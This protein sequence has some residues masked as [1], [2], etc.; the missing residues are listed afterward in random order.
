MIAS[1]IYTSSRQGLFP[2]N[3][4]FSVVGCTRNLDNAIRKQLEDMSGY[5]PLFPHYSPDAWNNPVNYSHR[6]VK[7]GGRTLHVLSRIC[8]NGVDYTQRSNKLA[9][10]LAMTLDE[11][12]RLP[13]GPASVFF[14]Q[15]L[16]KDASW[17]IRTGYLDDISSLSDLNCKLAPCLTWKKLTGDAG[18]AGAIMEDYLLNQDKTFYFAFDPSASQYNL[19]LVNEAMQL[20]SVEQRWK[21]S[22]STFFTENIAGNQCNWRFCPINSDM[23]EQA[24]RN[25]AHNVVFD[26]TQNHPEATGGEMVDLARNGER[27]MKISSLSSQQTTPAV[28][29]PHQGPMI[30][31]APMNIPLNPPNYPN[32]YNIPGNHNDN[33]Y[34]LAFMTCVVLCMVIAG[35]FIGFKTNDNRKIEELGKSLAETQKVAIGVL[36]FQHQVLLEKTEKKEQWQIPVFDSHEAI[37]KET[38]LLIYQRAKSSAK[39]DKT[40][41]KKALELDKEV[42]AIISEFKEHQEMIEASIRKLEERKVLN[43]QV[44]DYNATAEK[45]EGL[46]NLGNIIKINTKE[47][48]D[49]EKIFQEK[50]KQCIELVKKWGDI[51]GRLCNSFPALRYPRPA[52]SNVKNAIPSK[53]IPVLPSIDTAW[54]EEERLIN[55]LKEGKVFM[56]VFEDILPDV[57]EVKVYANKKLVVKDKGTYKIDASH[58][59]FSIEISVLENEIEIKPNKC[60]LK[61]IERLEL[62]IGLYYK[63]HSS[64]FIDFFI[65]DNAKLDIEGDLKY[66]FDLQSA[67]SL[68]VLTCNPSIHKRIEPLFFANFQFDNDGVKQKMEKSK[69][70]WQFAFNDPEVKKLLNCLASLEEFKK[71]LRSKYK[72]KGIV[73]KSIEELG[74]Y[75]K[76]LSSKEKKDALFS[77]LAEEIANKVSLGDLED[78]PRFDSLPADEVKKMTLVQ[79]REFARSEIEKVLD[80]KIEG[81]RIIFTPKNK[82]GGL[83]ETIIP[84]NS[85]SKEGF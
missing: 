24:R 7:V 71:K 59:D 33:G 13:S 14:N 54:R 49:E 21:V 78:L 29:P 10:H 52:P 85:I 18:W 82:E 22:F 30:P 48:N 64:V 66:R 9:S 32:N 55:A 2:G 67:K 20:L 31:P 76:I 46:V 56:A 70:G 51:Q 84:F 68:V 72:N 25:S 37:R 19:E 4:G 40:L 36:E 41:E 60:A 15:G 65:S 81:S 8:F 23:L 63:A 77:E 44:E 27:K 53:E 39:D 62:S 28:V 35:L 5:T 34:K 43:K 17:E 57:S 38:L 58:K 74:A 80:K 75:K 11:C 42:E 3:T 45:L 12:Q 79:L 1:L 69:S 26:L 47:E 83:G 6:I 16:F 61:G 50:L 73:P